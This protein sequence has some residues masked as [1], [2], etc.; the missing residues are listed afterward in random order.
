[1]FLVITADATAG[2]RR[3]AAWQAVVVAAVV[4]ATFTLFGQ[5]ILVYLLGE[6]RVSAL[7][8]V[9]ADQRVLGIVAKADLLGTHDHPVDGAQRLAGK[10]GAAAHPADPHGRDR[11]PGAGRNA[12]RAGA[13][14]S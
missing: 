8:V 11:R 13:G 3:R 4:I 9:D 2:E 14:S 6:R 10:P 5:Q 12:E 1:M 7:P